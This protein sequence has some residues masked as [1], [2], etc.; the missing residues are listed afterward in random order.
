MFA[1]DM[2]SAIRDGHATSRNLVE[3]S[4]QRIEADSA[5]AAWTHVDAEGALARADECD[6]LRQSGRPLGRLHGVPV[7]LKDIIDVAGM[8]CEC[9]AAAM[10]GRV[11]KTDARLVESLRAEGAVIIGKT[12]TTELAFMQPAATRNPVNPAHT[13]GGSSSGS[14]AAVAAGHVPLAVGSQTNGSVIRPASFCGTFAIKP[15]AGIIPRSGV[16][17]TSGTLDQMG[18]FGRSLEDIGLLC[19][20]LGSYDQRDPASHARPRPLMHDGAVAEVPIEPN[21]LWFDMPYFDRL[22]PAARDG[23]EELLG[24]LGDRVERIDAAD[25]FA[26]FIAAQKIIHGHEYADL[27]GWILDESPDGLSK[28]SQDAIAL[29]RTYGK[30]AYDEAQDMRRQA[31]AFFATLFTEFDAVISP[32]ALGEAP[33]FETGTGDPICQTIFTL[34]GLPAVTLPLLVGDND[35]P[36][37]VQLAGGAEEDD[38]LLRTSRWLLAALAE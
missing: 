28:G 2:V 21:F 11:P 22:T 17:A 7:G 37:G 12:V 32:A 18:V 30:A 1:T 4:L 3:S 10:K 33:L 8:P 38:R 23:M 27:L 26:G 9:G 34:A 29:G 14:A 16:L 13:P 24:A 5:L 25:S 6:K 15:T 36:I 35:L 19:D 31:M 20:V